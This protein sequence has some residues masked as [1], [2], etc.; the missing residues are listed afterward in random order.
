MG[1]NKDGAKSKGECVCLI[2][3]EG[4]SQKQ[5]QRFVSM[6]SNCVNIPFRQRKPVCA[7]TANQVRGQ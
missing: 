5:A 3:G 6:F 1:Q 4:E 2:D 7:V